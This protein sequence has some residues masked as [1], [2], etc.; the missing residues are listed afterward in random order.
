MRIQIV[1]NLALLT[2][3]IFFAV[4]TMAQGADPTD[5][6]AKDSID[7]KP[8][9]DDQHV[10]RW[11]VVDQD[12]FERHGPVQIKV[13]SLVLQAGEPATGVRFTGKFPKTDYE[14]ALEAKRTAG[15]DFF[16]GLTFPVGEGSLTLIMGG[17]SGWVV[18]LSCID[19]AYAID[20]DTCRAIRFKQDQW[21]RVRVRV[22]DKLVEVLVDD[23]HLI[24]LKT[25]GHKLSV[26]DE[27]KPCLP[28]G[29]ATWK[30][31]G[32]I[33]KIRYRPLPAK[34]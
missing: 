16:C 17:W 25:D 19:G 30:T 18:G 3:V 11:Q 21:Y 4:G 28:L 1:C 20:N 34:D 26:S 2:T 7:W 9:C 5:T 12:D 32:A 6:A 13:D 22:A 10:D 27:M 24:E 29:I 33:R 31:T 14:L 15:N 23:E 8:L